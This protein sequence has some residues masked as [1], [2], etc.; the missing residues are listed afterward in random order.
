MLRSAANTAIDTRGRYH[1]SARAALRGI[2]GSKVVQLQAVAR[3]SLLVIYKMLVP[4][5]T[6]KL[7]QKILPRLVTVG[8]YD[9]VHP[10]LTAATHGGKVVYHN[11]IIAPKF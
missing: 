2:S 10:S 8:S 5:F 3:R 1:R 11:N 6:L 7:N 9:G 4:I